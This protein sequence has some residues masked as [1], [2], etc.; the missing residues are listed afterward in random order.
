MPAGAPTIRTTYGSLHIKSITTN[1][2][3]GHYAR[4]VMKALA[5]EIPVGLFRYLL[6]RQVKPRPAA[7]IRRH[8]NAEVPY[9]KEL[10]LIACAVNYSEC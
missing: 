10:L 2:S 8:N 4:V 9:S 7:E 6:W 5:T 1:G 3:K